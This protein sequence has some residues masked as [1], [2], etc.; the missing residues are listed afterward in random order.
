MNLD[1]LD[2]YL[3]HQPYGDIYGAWR[4]LVASQKAGKVHAIGIF[5]FKAAKIIEFV[6]LKS[7]KLK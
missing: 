4:A 6:G 5:N 2:L 3:I 1:Y 7:I